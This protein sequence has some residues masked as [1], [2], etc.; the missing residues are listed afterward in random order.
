MRAPIFPQGYRQARAQFRALAATAGARLA[1]RELPGQTGAAGEAL[2]IDTVELGH[3]EGGR[4][5][6]V[7]SGAHGIEGF[8]GSVVQ[9]RWLARWLAAANAGRAVSG[10]TLVLVHAL[11]PWGF[12]HATRC[13]EGNVDLNRNFLA[14]GAEPPA[15]PGYGA[16]HDL[17]RTPAWSAAEAGRLAEALENYARAHG[18]QALTDAMLGG[19]YDFSDGLNYG[20]RGLAWANRQALAICAELARRHEALT[21]IDLH[22][23]VAPFGEA[24]LLTFAGGP[25]EA[26]PHPLLPP[27]DA[28]FHAGAAGLASMTGITVS[29]IARTLAPLPVLGAVLEFGTVARTEIRAALRE[30]LWLRLSPP[31]DPA[32]A[33]AAHAAIRRAFYPD[34][35]AWRASLLGLA[36][37]LFDHMLAAPA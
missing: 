8:A 30:D 23:G 31:A 26:A 18:A 17:L 37:A 7:I 14:P 35:P 34:D 24:A 16:I 10:R 19:Q 5:L 32:R 13:D 28:R 20:G 27:G 2:A 6:V 11:N 9:A 3:G 22:T 1:V 15:N 12:S 21:I 33:A 4:A 25:P 36:D 29:G